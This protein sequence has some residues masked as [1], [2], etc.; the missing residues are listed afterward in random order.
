M[1]DLRP[2]YQSIEDTKK[3]ISDGNRE[4]AEKLGWEMCN[5]FEA[6]YQVNESTYTPEMCRLQLDCLATILEIHIMR[7]DPIDIGY[8]YG[9]FLQKFRMDM[10]HFPDWTDEDKRP[11]VEIAMRMTRKVERFYTEKT[12][13]THRPK[14]HQPGEIKCL[15]CKKKPADKP[16][17][18]MVPHLLIARTFSYDGSKDREKVVVDVTNL[19][20]G[21]KEKYFGH[22]VYDDTVNELIGRSLTDDEIEEENKKVNALTRDYVFCEDCEKRFSTIES[23]Y[24]EILDG[25]KNYPPEIPY[26]FWL[27]VM[28]RMSVGEMGC[29][30]DRDHEEKLRKV[31]DKCLAIKREDIITKRSKLGYCAY[32]L[33][34]ANDTRDETLGIF[35]HHSSTIPYQALMGDILINFYASS[36]RAHSFCRQHHLPEEDLNEGQEP[37][38][39]REMSFIEFW[40]VKRQILDEIWR[41]DRSVWN[42]GQQQHQTLSRYE[43]SDVDDFMTRMG[44][45]KC[46][47]EHHDEYSAWVTSESPNVI[48]FPRSIRKIL[49][50]IKEHK[51]EMSLEKMSEDLGYTKEELE[52]MLSYF[53]KQ[54]EMIEAKEKAYLEDGQMLNEM[55]MM[56]KSVFHGEI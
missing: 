24:A 56:D 16:G 47:G 20:E 14:A 44:F 30:M 27:S 51:N 13:A 37:E 7:E 43:K 29:K 15:L 19:S 9:Q 8:R 22:H 3:A 50:W 39:M 18:H 53:V 6:S 1:E 54:A 2:L 17:S 32:S 31:L 38:K 11:A 25:K 28:W 5:Q 42:L 41:H 10:D 40:C 23:Y 46:E 21:Y 55:L 4:L 49:V 35:G 45:E 52:V 34:R 12:R 33:Y 36:S 26:L 48:M